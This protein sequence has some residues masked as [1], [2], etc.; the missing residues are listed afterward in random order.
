MITYFKNYKNK[1]NPG[2]HITPYEVIL[3][4]VGSGQRLVTSARDL[5]AVRTTSLPG[6]LSYEV[7]VRFIGGRVRYT[8]RRL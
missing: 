5:A 1:K 4:Y 2:F 8:V 3:W 7:A 6:S